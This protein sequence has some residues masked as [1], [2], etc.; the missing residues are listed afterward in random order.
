M[1]KTS[2]I[3]R[4]DN[5]TPGMAAASSLEELPDSE[6]RKGN[7]VTEERCGELVSVTDHGS[8]HFLCGRVI[9]DSWQPVMC[10]ECISVCYH[11]YT[12]TDKRKW[13]GLS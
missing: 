7:G 10:S 2:S 3:L 11:R 4:E 6:G 8:N 9:K 5:F 13:P 12:G 1:L